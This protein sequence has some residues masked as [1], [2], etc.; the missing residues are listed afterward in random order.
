VPRILQLLTVAAILT[1]SWASPQAPAKPAAPAAPKPAVAAPPRALVIQSVHPRRIEVG[2]VLEIE[3]RGFTAEEGPP[4]IRLAGVLATADKSVHV[5]LDV[6]GIFESPKRIVYKFTHEDF[7]K[8]GSVR[9]EFW[10]NVHVFCPLPGGQFAA[11]SFPAFKGQ[12]FHARLFPPTLNALAAEAKAAGVVPTINLVLTYVLLGIVWLVL[13]LVFVRLI[14]FGKDRP[15]RPAAGAARSAS[16]RYLTGRAMGL[17]MVVLISGAVAG[18]LYGLSGPI[19]KIL[20]A[21]TGVEYAIHI[22]LAFL[23]AFLLVNFALLYAGPITWVERRVAARMQSRVGPNRVGPQGLLQWL[24]DGLKAVMKED[25]IPTNADPVLFRIAPY[26][27]FGAIFT[28]F[29]VLPFSATW[30][31]TDLNVGILLVISVTSIVVPG[32]IAAGWSSNNKWSLFGGMRAAAQIVSYE[33]PASLAIL[34]VIIYSGSLSMQDMIRMQ[35]GAP[36]NWFIF[37]NPFIF[38]SFFLFFTSSLAE[39]NR[40]PFDLP[41]AESEL[42]SGYNTEYSGMRFLMFFVGEYVNIYVMSAIATTIFLGG[43]RIP[44][45]SVAAQE[46]SVGLQILGLFIFWLKVGVLSFVVIWLRWTLPR[47]R[48]DQLMTMCWKYFVPL[49]FV[50]FIGSTVWFMAFSET[51]WLDKGLRILWFLGGMGLVGYLFY[52]A[53]WHFKHTKAELYA[54][55]LI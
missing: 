26:L 16:M 44:L 10:G 7:V 1:P 35:G 37:H 34:S 14:L 24:A 43:W 17:G 51:G 45:V 22:G 20:N 36:W 29:S 18:A 9:G 3:G 49:A 47:L 54:N 13:T 41:E 5:S 30:A 11:G 33:I 8:L 50:C 6:K 38:F 42:V 15:S 39:G 32:L 46:E 27:V 19:H 52:R 55:P 2:S 53:R 28:T 25:V 21:L 48:V 40:A 12:S 23:A 31:A 4:Q